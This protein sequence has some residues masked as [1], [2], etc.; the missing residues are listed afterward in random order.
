MTVVPP[1]IQSFELARRVAQK[2]LHRPV[3]VGFGHLQLVGV[4]CSPMKEKFSGRQA[5]LGAQLLGL[6]QQLARGGEVVRDDV[7]R[8]HL[9][10]GYCTH[11]FGASAVAAAASALLIRSTVG[12]SQVPVIR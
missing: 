12:L 2:F 6:A 5:M 1:R 8:G 7:T 9:N 3:A 11:Y 10:G 4:A